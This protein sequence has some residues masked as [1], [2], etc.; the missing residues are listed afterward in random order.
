[1]LKLKFL[2]VFIVIS[3]VLTIQHHFIIYRI[4]QNEK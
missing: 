4:V 3:W 2:M 1:M